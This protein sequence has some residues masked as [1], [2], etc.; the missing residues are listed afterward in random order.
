MD[1]QEVKCEPSLHG[2]AGVLIRAGELSDIQYMPCN[3]WGRILFFPLVSS[4]SIIHVQSPALGN[5]SN[6]SL[7][8]IE[9][10]AHVQYEKVKLS[11][12]SLISFTFFS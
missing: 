10:S 2:R 12:C 9:D 6:I 11:Y 1:W 3:F 4:I 8:K 7:L 5:N